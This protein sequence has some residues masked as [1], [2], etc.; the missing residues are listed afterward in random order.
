[1]QD[2][3]VMAGIVTYNPELNLLEENLKVLIEQ[4]DQIWIVD[5]GSQNQCELKE[6]LAYFNQIDYV[7]LKENKGIAY[8]LNRIMGIAEREKYLWVITLDQDSMVPCDI[9]SSNKELME[10]STDI[11]IIAA[12][13]DD[14]NQVH[15][16]PAYEKRK[17]YSEINECITSA[18]ITSVPIWKEI[19]RF[20]EKMFIDLVDVE[21]CLRAKKHGKRIVRNN[22]VWLSHTVGNIKE[23]RF[24]WKWTPVRNHSAFRKYYQ[25]RNLFYMYKK[26]YGTFRIAMWRDVFVAYFKVLFYENDKK[27]K[28]IKMNHG[29]RDGLI[30]AKNIDEGHEL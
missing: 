9:I 23:Y 15:K 20:D 17:K 5:N 24:L 1:M 27:N 16:T 28:I 3:L 21:Y 22:E 19:N 11:A 10:S 6:R 2:K 26:I 8:A 18:S 29:V 13:I 30:M 4:V 14:R 25:I 7:L 12:V